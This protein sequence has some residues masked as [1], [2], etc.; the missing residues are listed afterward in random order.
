[1]RGPDAF[2]LGNTNLPQG[3]SHSSPP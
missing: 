2:Q 3:I 1:L